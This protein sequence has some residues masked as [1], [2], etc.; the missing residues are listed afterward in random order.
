MDGDGPL[1]RDVLLE[2][3]SCGAVDSFA[4]NIKYNTGHI[5]RKPY[6]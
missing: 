4:S 5:Q 3:E 1:V 2:E 6:G